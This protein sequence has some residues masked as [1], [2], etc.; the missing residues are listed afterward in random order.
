LQGRILHLTGMLIKKPLTWIG[1]SGMACAAVAF[2]TAVPAQ[3]E[4]YPPSTSSC[5]YSNSVTQPNA[6]YVKGITPGSTITISCAA[7]SFPDSSEL[8]IIEASGL[9]AIVSPASAELDEVDL[10]SLQV[11][12]TGSDGSLTDT[13]TVPATYS[14]SDPNAVCPATQAQINAG[15]ACDLV[16]VNSSLSPVNE[17]QLTYR[18]QGRP[19]R[20][21]LHA[22]VTSVTRGVK[23]LTVSDDRGACPTP[24][25][26]TSHC[27]WGAPVTG[28]PNPTAFAGIP[29][30]EALVGNRLAANT[31]SVSPAVYCQS[32]A[33]AAACSGLPAGTL[34]PPALSGTITVRRGLGF[35]IV[36][37]PDTTPYFGD[38][39]LR[40]LEAGTRN[41][42]SATFV[43]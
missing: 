21:T 31:I 40:P 5:Q 17:A 37:E 11:V 9:A 16:L 35:V 15:L 42:E 2:A 18:G 14:A 12:T 25:T 3:A 4:A 28:A 1:L 43:W 20:P 39:F 22:K 24:V 34:V 27:W 38:G 7:G 19:N 29:G 32:G 6:N 36:D 8:I 10:G 41:V 23:T 13:Y 26:A 33:T 30:F